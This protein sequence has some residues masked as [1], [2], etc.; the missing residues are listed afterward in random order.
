MK[1][2]FIKLYEEVGSQ[3]ISRKKKKGHNFK[4]GISYIK[5]KEESRPQESE[6]EVDPDEFTLDV[7]EFFFNERL[8]KDK[9]NDELRKVAAHAL[10]EATK[11]SEAMDYVPRPPGGIPGISWLVQQAVQI[12]YRRAKNQGIYEAVRRTVKLKF[13]TAYELATMNLSSGL[14]KHKKGNGQL[15]NNGTTTIKQPAFLKVQ[16][17][18][19][20]LLERFDS[21]EIDAIIQGLKL[22]LIQKVTPLSIAKQQQIN[23]QIPGPFNIIAQP[24][25]MTCWATVY[26]MLESWKRK[27]SIRIE[28]ALEDLGAKWLDLFKK[29]KG[30]TSTDKVDFIRAAGLKDYAPFNPSIEGWHG[31]LKDH[32]PIWVTT[33]ERPG[34]NWAI[35]AR[36]I[37]GIDGDGSPGG[38]FFTI[39][40]PAGGRKY[41]ESISVFWPKFEDEMSRTGN[42]RIQILH[43]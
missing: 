7:L 25:N 29:N 3:T 37:I 10:W 41:K 20:D 15:I 18:V 35:H 39:V 1:N 5:T 42:G 14:S 26:T 2:R 16:D 23:Y 40:D 30:L 34:G 4:K 27:Q 6:V 17:T 22:G 24:T 12:A 33:N 36:I 11:A 32:G 31:M 19:K 38:T 8:T 28:T 43:W 9:L 13:R 21:E